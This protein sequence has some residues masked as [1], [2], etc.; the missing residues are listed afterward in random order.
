MKIKAKLWNEGQ[1]NTGIIL[2]TERNGRE[3]SQMFELDD[4]RI[5]TFI[6]WAKEAFETHERRTNANGH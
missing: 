6:T 3:Y 4:I 2:T 1:K 5:N